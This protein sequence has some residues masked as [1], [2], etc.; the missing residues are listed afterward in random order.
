M[1]PA[2]SSQRGPSVWAV[3]S[4]QVA[5]T[6]SAWRQTQLLPL[7]LSSKPNN[8]QPSITHT[9]HVCVCA[10][11]C[12]VRTRLDWTGGSQ[13]AS[14]STSLPHFLSSLSAAASGLTPAPPLCT[15]TL[16]TIPPNLAHLPK[17]LVMYSIVRVIGEC[18]EAWAAYVPTLLGADGVVN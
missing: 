3:D 13:S 18:Y 6:E 1:V 15:C 4:G 11:S 5:G 16:H 10:T 2:D 17:I 7:S 14:S 9:S 8:P 12:H